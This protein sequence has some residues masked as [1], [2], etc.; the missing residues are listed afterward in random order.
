M[1]LKRCSDML[2]EDASL[3]EALEGLTLNKLPKRDHHVIFRKKHTDIHIDYIKLFEFAAKGE[4]IGEPAGEPV[5]EPA[6]LK[7]PGN[8]HAPTEEDAPTEKSAPTEKGAPKAPGVFNWLTRK[9][10][11]PQKT[12]TPQKNPT[13]P[14]L[15][16]WPA[17]PPELKT[18]EESLLSSPPSLPLQSPY[19]LYAHQEEAI[20]WALKREAGNFYGIKGGILALS[21]GLGKTLISMSVVMTTYKPGDTATLIVT[22]KSLMMNYMT[23]AKKFFGPC[24]KAFVMDRDVE[25]IRFHKFTKQDA[26]QNHIII[27][28]VDTITA[29]AK[30]C[31]K[32]T[33]GKGN[34]TLKGVGQAFF[35]VPW[36]RMICDESH[37]VSNHKTQLWEALK[38]VPPGKRIL[39]TGT[40]VRSYQDGI[41]SQL[42][43]AGMNILTNPRH[44]T[45]QNFNTYKLRE[46]LFVKSQCETT[47]DLPP[48]QVEQ[49]KV[50]FSSFEKEVY[51]ILLTNSRKIY[52]GF[53]AKDGTLFANVL[54]QFTR[55]RQACIALFLITPQSKLKKLS[56]SEQERM[57]EGSLLGIEHVELE[58]KIRL[59]DGPAGL[60]SAKIL[61]L[62]QIAKNVPKNEKLIV[63]SQWA[64]SC[65]LASKALKNTFG[66]N[67]VIFADGELDTI[68]RDKAF[69]TFR[70]D[71]NIRF[72]CMTSIGSEGLTLTEANH[73]II[74]EP[75]FTSFTNE[76]AMGRINRIG[77]T[78]PTFVHQLITNN[79]FEHRMLEILSSKHNI[80]EILLNSGVNT[81]VIDAFFT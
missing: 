11:T 55:M 5:G 76:Q 64:T 47:I 56:E 14:A 75:G 42:S 73:M 15:F 6:P 77:Q 69:Q 9:H 46:A 38:A 79:S 4:P 2:H 52:A 34:E 44:W 78:R 39:L 22:P 54:E 17:P 70:L 48:S 33:K 66:A 62:L 10:P 1:N 58:R 60:Q 41:F 26:Y 13:P 63:F 67:A 20:R 31:G 29:L 21:V 74:M 40:V 53:K 37:R 80:K 7:E 71:S 59:C 72:L 30:A 36:V 16:I 49:V 51:N 43:I 3:I 68:E 12:P 61:Q 65:A 19:K 27:V 24:L 35:E 50:E 32:V 57:Q 23:D 8:K 18:N 28:S 81:E 25:P 45:I